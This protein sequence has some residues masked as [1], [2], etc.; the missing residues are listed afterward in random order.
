MKMNYFVL[1]TNDREAANAFY[2]AL[3]SETGFAR[4][5]E[6]DRMTYWMHEGDAFAVA[7]PINGEPAR[8]GNG[9]MAGF[10]LESSEQVDDLYKK[11]LELGGTS[12]GTPGQRGP[13]YSCYVR[14][15]DQNKLCFGHFTGM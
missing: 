2:D 10:G 6:T 13:Y 3:F 4:A 7:E 1:G 9:T 8:H 12:E 14:D 5:M 15:L 11:A